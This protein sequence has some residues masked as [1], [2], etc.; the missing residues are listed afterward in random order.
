MAHSDLRLERRFVVGYMSRDKQSVHSD[1]RVG[2]E[3]RH[4][5]MSWWMKGRQPTMC[6]RMISEW[7]SVSDQ[8]RATETW[9]EDK[10]ELT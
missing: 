4:T 8:N 5:I 2:C 7:S 1:V 3:V 9:V 10:T 6:W